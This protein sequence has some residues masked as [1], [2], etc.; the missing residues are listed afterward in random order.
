MNAPVNLLNLLPADAE[1]VLREFALAQGE[2]AY[3]GTQVVQHLWRNPVEEFAQIT[4]LPAGFRQRLAEHFSM[5]R[6][7]V[8]AR[9][10]SRD[11]TQKFL[12]SLPDGQG[13]EAVAIPEE[14][15]TT[16]C[17]SSQAGCALRCAFCATG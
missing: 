3:R 9:Q 16:L 7:N 5:P 14:N 15:R 10:R 11:G 6:L 12:F 1:R 4:T 2:P 17:I 13:I 8:L